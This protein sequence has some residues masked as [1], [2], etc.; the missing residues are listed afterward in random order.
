MLNNDK[1]R[2][3]NTVDKDSWESAS[4]F[5]FMLTFIYEH[6]Q[7]QKDNNITEEFIAEADEAFTGLYGQLHKKGVIPEFD[8]MTDIIDYCS[9]NTNEIFD[10][11]E[12]NIII[13]FRFN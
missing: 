6:N 1:E 9:N 7:R 3:N 8:Q 13:E 12:P 4:L 5:G 11:L 2:E 10:K